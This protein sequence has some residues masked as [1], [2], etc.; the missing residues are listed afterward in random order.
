[1]LGFKNVILHSF[2]IFDIP[3]LKLCNG[4]KGK[5]RYKPDSDPSSIKFASFKDEFHALR[6]DHVNATSIWSFTATFSFRYSS[7]SWLPCDANISF[8]QFCT[9]LISVTLLT[10]PFLRSMDVI[11]LDNTPYTNCLHASTM[12]DARHVLG[13]QYVTKVLYNRAEAS[14]HYAILP[15]SKEGTESATIQWR[16][17]HLLHLMKHLHFS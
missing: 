8:M 7:C 10:W 2:N 5:R 17:Q 13:L 12:T 3:K 4:S 14:V 11:H 16:Q 15:H 1:M 6:F 9:F